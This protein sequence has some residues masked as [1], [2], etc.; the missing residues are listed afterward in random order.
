MTA[1]AGLLPVAVPVDVPVR[2][3]RAGAQEAAREEL[4]R[5]IYRDA[6]PG[7]TERVLRWVVEQVTR[8]LDEVAGVSPGGY[9]GVAMLVVLLVAAAVAIRLR[10]GPLARAAARDAA[11]F[12]GADVTAAEHRAR[13][14]RHAAAA[15]WAEAVRERLRAVV[16]SLEE[17][18]LLEPRPGRTAD[19]A[20]AEG[21]VVLPSCAPDL[22]AAARRFDEI[23]YG[24]RPATRNDDALLRHL[25]DLVGAARVARSDAPGPALVPPR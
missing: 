23:W 21:G 16:R 15:Q 19:E 10:V 17:R 18:A 1:P 9:A 25:D 2:L 3:G 13:A 7:L 4:A 14:D 8:L 6:G 11:L 20:A 12:T 5:Q 22:R 24:E